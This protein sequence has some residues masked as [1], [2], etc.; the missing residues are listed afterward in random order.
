[1][2]FD[3]QINLSVEAD[4]ELVAEKYIKE[5]MDEV[6]KTENHVSSWDYVEYIVEDP[7]DIPWE[8]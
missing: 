8:R 7:Q 6:V 1:M 5:I 2:K 3:I 4:N